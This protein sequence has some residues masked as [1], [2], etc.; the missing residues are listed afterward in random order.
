LTARI[1]SAALRKTFLAAGFCEDGNRF[2]LETPELQ[3]GVDVTGVCRLAG[4][5][6][7][8]HTICPKGSVQR[9]LTEELASHHHGSPC[10]RIWASQSVDPGLVLEQSAAIVDAFQALDDVTH[11]DADRPDVRPEAL[12]GHAPSAGPMRS[13]SAAD[14]ELF[15]K[16]LKATERDSLLQALE[17]RFEQHPQRHAGLAWAPVRARLV[18]QPAALASLQAM[19]ASGGEPDV[20]GHEAATGQ[21]V[22]C[23]CSA[24]SPAG[25]R[26]L[27]YDRAALDARKENKPEGSAMEAAAAMGLRLLGEDEYRALQQ[28][29]EFDLKTSSWLATPPAVR[30]LGGALFG[31]RR[32]GRV[33]VYHNG[34]PSYYAARGFRALLRV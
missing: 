2:V 33:F 10:P 3:H 30:A 19:E 26:S 34:A 7:I 8:D 6:S 13:L 14:N 1:A 23:D 28:L 4:F 27:C 25:R 11:Y 22:F 17:A 18:A 20:I 5:V 32:Y 9:I 29:G 21:V 31:D 24:E 16:P 12:V 15:M